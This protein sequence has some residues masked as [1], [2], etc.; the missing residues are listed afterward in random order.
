MLEVINCC[1]VQTTGYITPGMKTGGVQLID[2]IAKDE[3]KMDLLEKST[4]LPFLCVG[5]WKVDLNNC[6]QSHW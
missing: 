4:N 3:I 1:V 5:A 2:G 6:K